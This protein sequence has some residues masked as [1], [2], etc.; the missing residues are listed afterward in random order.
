M[1]IR[2]GSMVWVAALLVAAALTLADKKRLEITRALVLEPHE[3][4]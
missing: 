3:A 4:P 1:R 2:I